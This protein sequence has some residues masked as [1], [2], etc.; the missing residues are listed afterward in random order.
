ME[1][2]AVA[3]KMDVFNIITTY[4][5]PSICERRI[6]GKNCCIKSL[7]VLSDLSALAF[8]YNSDMMECLGLTSLVFLETM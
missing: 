3:T 4:N 6:V 1:R 7:T 8:L 5:T 2:C